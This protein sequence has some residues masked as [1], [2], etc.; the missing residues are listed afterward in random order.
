MEYP[1]LNAA[2]L[3]AER[4]A[5][6][7]LQRQQIPVFADN[8]GAAVGAA[9]N[10]MLSVAARDE[11]PTEWR[12]SGEV[13]IDEGLCYRQSRLIWPDGIEGSGDRSIL[14]YFRLMFPMQ[15]VPSC[16]EHTNME[17]T[18]K[19]YRHIDQSLLFQFLGIRFNMN[20]DGNKLA[21]PKYWDNHKVD[22]KEST[23]RSPDYGARFGMTRHRFQQIQQCLRFSSFDTGVLEDDPWIPIRPFIDAF[24]ER[25]STVVR[26]GSDIVIDECM[27]AWKGMEKFE[28]IFVLPHTTKIM[29]L[30]L[31]VK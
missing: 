27:S 21:I 16:L 29:L 28:C 30:G 17:L 10:P 22:V 8:G 19:Q 2:D 5:V 4:E 31:I 7:G 14:E 13:S 15:I 3:E 12:E 25:R 1:E 20:L 9:I 24:N 23:F 18:R 6:Y 11:V 26:A